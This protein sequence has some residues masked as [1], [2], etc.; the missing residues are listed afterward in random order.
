MC[1]DGTV[2]GGRL[3]VSWV[4]MARPYDPNLLASV[5]DFLQSST[6]EKGARAV[7]VVWFGAW[8]LMFPEPGMSAGHDLAELLRY[9]RGLAM[10][11]P[12]VIVL[13]PQQS[14]PMMTARVW[15]PARLHS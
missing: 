5:K 14:I 13:G 12:A 15:T 6:A 10:E 2:C 9:F 7:S 8:Y 11:F 3:K 4:D 1:H